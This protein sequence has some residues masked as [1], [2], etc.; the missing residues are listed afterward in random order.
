VAGSYNVVYTQYQERRVFSARAAI[1]VADSDVN[2][3]ELA[4]K[5]PVDVSGTVTAEGSQPEKM[6]VQVS[7]SPKDR[8]GQDASTRAGADGK[9]LIQS[10]AP[11]LSIVQIFNLPP[12]TYVKS[13]HLGDQDVRTGE[14][15][16][17]DRPSALLNIVLGE[18]GGEVDGRVQNA[19]GQPVATMLV[20]LA[21]SEEYG[22]RW[23]LLKQTSTDPSGNFRIQ[24]VAPGDYK[25]F[26][27][28]IDPD[29][30][31]QFAEFRKTFESRSASVT[32]GPKDK[33]AVQLTVI[34]AED[35]EKERSKLP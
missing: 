32:V 18:D 22:D 6:G 30:G 24:D 11:E 10:A 27:W 25:V 5:P 3:L 8:G 33:A 35:V 9:F 1:H 26:A 20:T 31:A 2:G 7:L 4:I 28:E 12:G 29:G 15:D 14:I 21:P 17:S 16:L 19:S 34:T 23:D 13:I